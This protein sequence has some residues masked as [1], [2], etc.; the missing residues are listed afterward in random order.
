MT[1]HE[2]KADEPAG[3]RSARRD[4]LAAGVAG[5][6]SALCGMVVMACSVDHEGTQSGI[7]SSVV[8]TLDGGSPGLDASVLDSSAPDAAPIVEAAAPIDA[9]SRTPDPDSGPLNALLATAYELATAYGACGV[10]IQGAPS[11]DPFVDM[12]PVLRD[13]TVSFQAHHKA[14][15]QELAAAVV[16][17]GGKP[18]TEQE[19]TSK[20]KA[21]EALRK[22]PTISNVLKYAAQRERAAVIAC[23]RTIGQLEASYYRYL[24]SS[25]EGVEAQHFTLW[26]SLLQGLAQAGPQFDPSKASKVVPTA[27][28]RVVEKQ[29]GLDTVPPRYFG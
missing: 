26:L 19:V 15:A 29:P 1:S 14:H 11:S 9:A 2:E 6:A 4:V 22:N 21:P 24:V 10:L 28:V 27:F 17:L 23:N 12:A 8:P 7:D 5:V 16:N 20:F 25:I 3:D 13:T 18:I